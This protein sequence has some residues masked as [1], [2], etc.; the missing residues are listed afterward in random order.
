MSKHHHF[1]AHLNDARET[2]KKAQAALVDRECDREEY[3]CSG[4]R[5]EDVEKV[6]TYG[7][8]VARLESLDEEDRLL[9]DAL[10]A[11]ET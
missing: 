4:K 8:L 3:I 9:G 1:D 10:L 2:L 5:D 6:I 11:L 7:R